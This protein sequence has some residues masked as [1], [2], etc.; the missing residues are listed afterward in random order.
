MYRSGYKSQRD[1]SRAKSTVDLHSGP[2]GQISGN[3]GDRS[4]SAGQINRIKGV[5]SEKTLLD[6][7]ADD[8]YAD[9]GFEGEYE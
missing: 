8:A 2:S 1:L 7:Y 4:R 9:D 5:R 3:I 6:E